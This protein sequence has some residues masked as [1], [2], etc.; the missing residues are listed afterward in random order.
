MDVKETKELIAGLLILVKL[1]EPLKDGVQL[2]DL[3]KVIEIMNKNPEIMEK[4]KLAIDGIALVPQELKD[5]DLQEGIDLGLEI[6]KD[7]KK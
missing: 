2:A 4:V 6:L 5:L 7:L 3:A 1:I